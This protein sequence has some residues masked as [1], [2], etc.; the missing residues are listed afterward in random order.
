LSHAGRGGALAVEE[1]CYVVAGNPVAVRNRALASSRTLRKVELLPPQE[2]RQ[3]LL[4]LIGQ[5]HGAGAEEVATPVARMLGFQGTSQAL[6]E[7]IQV[8]LQVL[9]AQGHLE[10]HNGT[11]RRIDGV[12]TL[13]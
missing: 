5:A 13:S 11:L 7:R 8:Q 1:G 9:L 3:A 10:D 4:E 6:R 2:L 12:P